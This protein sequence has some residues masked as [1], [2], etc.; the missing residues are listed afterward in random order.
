MTDRLMTV[1]TEH[2]CGNPRIMMQKSKELLMA[3]LDQD[4]GIID[5]SLY[6]DVFQEQLGKPMKPKGRFRHET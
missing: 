4:K 6:F 5:E 1:L 3:A 2:A